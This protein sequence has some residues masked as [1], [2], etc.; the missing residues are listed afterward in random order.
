[1]EMIRWEGRRVPAT[2]CG[3]GV[4]AVFD[5]YGIWLCTKDYKHPTNRV[6]L[7]PEVLKNLNNF[8]EE[9]D[10]NGKPGSTLSSPG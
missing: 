6:F 5:G 10:A 8:V 7:E 9:V 1:M 2:Y 3:D 4:Y